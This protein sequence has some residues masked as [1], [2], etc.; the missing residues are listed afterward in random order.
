MVTINAEPSICYFVNHLIGALLG[1]FMKFVMVRR[2]E[3]MH[4]LIIIFLGVIFLAVVWSV[5]AG[6]LVDIQR[7]AHCLG[8][9]IENS[10]ISKIAIHR[11]LLCIENSYT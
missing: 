7:L 6:A 5:T 9:K 8:S 11:K 1:L 4:G 10:H 2:P 3:V